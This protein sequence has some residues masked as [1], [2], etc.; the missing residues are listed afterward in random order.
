MPKM[1]QKSNIIKEFSG[2][3]GCKIFLKEK[4]GL[5]YVEKIGEVKRNVERMNILLSENLPLPKIYF[6]DDSKFEME[7]IH[8]LDIRTYLFHYDVD[9][10]IEFILE[11]LNKFKSTITGYKNYEDVYEEKLNWLPKNF[12]I[13]RNELLKRLPKEFPESMYHGDLTLE[14]IIFSNKKFF[15]IDAVNIE[16]NS[17]IFDIA[18]LR[19][20][21]QCKW[22]LRHHNTHLDV[23]IQIINTHIQQQYP[24]AFDNHLLILM[25]LRVLKHCQPNDL[26]Y[27]FLIREIKK[28][29]K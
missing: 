24:E 17:Y 7:Y 22:F 20:D 18:K 6:S 27:N 25:L 3:S 26:N 9:N 5:L 19:Q 14:N 2:H 29:W 28:L 11:V 21:I 1:V 16:Y 8:G 23:K 12:F 4:N 13:N 10:L 15:L